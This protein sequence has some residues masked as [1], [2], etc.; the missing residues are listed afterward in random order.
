MGKPSASLPSFSNFSKISSPFFQHALYPFTE[1]SQRSEGQKDEPPTMA[2]VAAQT[3][4]E[5]LS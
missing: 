4:K 3:Q 2:K 5:T 1:S